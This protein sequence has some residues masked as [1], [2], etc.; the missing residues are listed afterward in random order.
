MTRPSLL[1]VH[2]KLS[3]L[4][5]AVKLTLEPLSASVI[6]EWHEGTH[7]CVVIECREKH[8]QEIVDRLAH[9]ALAG[10][11]D[12][13]FSLSY[14]VSRCNPLDWAEI[15]AYPDLSHDHDLKKAKQP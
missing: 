7:L 6:A 1:E 9:G 3:E 4:I 15:R 12:Y 11:Y 14:P 2:G 8:K 10:P 13:R 5:H